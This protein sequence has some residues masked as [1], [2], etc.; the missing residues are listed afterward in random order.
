MV[1]TIGSHLVDPYARAYLLETTGGSLNIP[2]HRDTH[3]DV[4]IDQLRR[5]VDREEFLMVGYEL[6]AYEAERLIDPSVAG[7][8]LVQA[9]RDY[10]QDYVFMRGLNVSFESV[11]LD[12]YARAQS[13]QPSRRPP[14]AAAMG[15]KKYADARPVKGLFFWAGMD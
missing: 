4:L 8:P 6:Q 11:W 3:V 12:R 14:I 7:D 10:V 15:L 13:S 9:S 1:L 5:S 2:N